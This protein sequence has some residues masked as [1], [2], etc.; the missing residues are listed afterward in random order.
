MAALAIAYE[1]RLTGSLAGT[2]TRARDPFLFFSV[3][4]V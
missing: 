3:C 2:S 1:R 4:V